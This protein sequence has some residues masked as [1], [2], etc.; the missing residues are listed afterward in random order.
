MGIRKSEEANVSGSTAVPGSI[1]SY[2]IL[3]SNRTEY[4][5]LLDQGQDF[6]A[7]YREWC[8]M[9]DAFCDGTLPESKWQDIATF[10]RKRQ[11]AVI[12]P[13]E[14]QTLADYYGE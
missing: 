8:A 2:R 9:D 11:V 4:L 10:L 12:E 5:I 1:D 6:D 14:V 7:L 13:F 3:K